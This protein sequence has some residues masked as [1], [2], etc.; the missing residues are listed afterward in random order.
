MSGDD[1]RRALQSTPFEPTA[2]RRRRRIAAGSTALAVALAVA[3]GA[4]WWR[5]APAPDAERPQRVDPPVPVAPVAPA[6]G[7][8]AASSPVASVDATPPP[9]PQGRLRLTSQP[10]GAHVLIDRRYRGQTPLTLSASPGAHAVW[11]F[12]SGHRRVER[13]VTLQE[14]RTERLEVEL[15]AMNGR[16]VV[17]TEPATTRFELAGRQLLGPAQKLSLPAGRYALRAE[18]AGHR[19][20]QS[21]VRVHPGFTSHH[22]VRMQGL[23]TSGQ[24]AEQGLFH[25]KYGLALKLLRPSN[26]FMGSQRSEHG[27][28]SNETRRWA[29]MRRPYYLGVTEVSNAQWRAFDPKHDSGELQ[30]IRMN[31]DNLPV[32]KISWQQAARYCNWLSAEHG[33]APFYANAADGEIIGVADGPRTGYRLP[34]EA[35]WSWAARQASERTERPF[36]WGGNWPPPKGSGNFADR[37]AGTLAAR[38]LKNYRDGHAATAPVGSG[39]ADRNGLF[40]MAGNVSEWTHDFYRAA[41]GGDQPDPLGPDSGAGHVVRG[42]H[43]LAGDRIALRI[44]YRERS[45]KAK[46]TI[47][48]RVARW[49]TPEEATAGEASSP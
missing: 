37:S 9:P 48:L 28:R 33:V 20:Y 17:E 13:T 7:V 46:P 45:E 11:L 39:Q 5:L 32:V 23:L 2:I 21:Q 15:A 18:H 36:P 42:G 8:P 35:E 43:W 14:N 22:T 3:L 10:S 29:S 30:G 25:L 44:A 38:R 24:D 1:G 26:F 19:A 16:L 34:T 47:G 31:Q 12:R 40:N 41:P 27:R 4:G 6:T 49:A